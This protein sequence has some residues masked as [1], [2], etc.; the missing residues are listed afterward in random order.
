[1]TIFS[2]GDFGVEIHWTSWE[3]GALGL[4]VNRISLIRCT[5]LQTK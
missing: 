4:D 3:A 2:T 1:M 5:N